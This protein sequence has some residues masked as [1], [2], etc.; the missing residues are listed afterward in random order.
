MNGLVFYFLAVVLIFAGIILW[1]IFRFNRSSAQLDVEKYR[2]KWLEIERQLTGNDQRLS[3]LAVIEA[4]KLLDHAM[5]EA[6]VDGDT[7]GDRLKSASS[8]WSNVDLIWKS[9]KLRNKI[10]HEAGFEATR[11]SLRQ[12]LKGYKV[13]LKDIGAI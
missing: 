9:H 5:R 11:E 3:Q 4:D 13:A 12:A 7:M 1:L 2:L 10:V 6:G 8:R